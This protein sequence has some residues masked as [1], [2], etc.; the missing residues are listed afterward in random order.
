MDYTDN[1]VK[2]TVVESHCPKY[3]P[4][5]IIRFIGSELDKDNSDRVCMVAMQA[6]YPF[7]YAFRRGGNLKS[8][9]YQCTDCG[10]TVVF[11]IEIE[12]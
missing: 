6:I 5:D 1:K 7:I 8:G 2:V 4:G 10:E 9:P 12:E 3:K 11:N